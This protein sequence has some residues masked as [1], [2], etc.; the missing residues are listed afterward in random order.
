MMATPMYLLFEISASIVKLV[1]WLK[2]KRAKRQ[3]QEETSEEEK[4]VTATEDDK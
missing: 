4:N 1:E 3:A 2:K